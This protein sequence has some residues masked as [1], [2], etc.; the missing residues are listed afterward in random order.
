MAGTMKVAGINIPISAETKEFKSE[1]KDV[2]ADLRHSA[3]LGK[4]LNTALKLD[5]TS[6]E[7]AEKAMN[8][9]E[10]QIKQSEQKTELLNKEFERL[11]KLDVPEEEMQKLELQI[12]KSKNQTQRLNNEFDKLDN[13][14][15]TMQM[16]D[17]GEEL[18]DSLQET[19]DNIEDINR[20]LSRMEKL[21][22]TAFQKITGEAY[23]TEQGIRDID[24]SMRGLKGAAATGAKAM[25]AG[26]VAMTVGA[27]AVTNAIGDLQDGL[28]SLGVPP[29]IVDENMD[30]F[31][32]WG[33]ALGI[34]GVNANTLFKGLIKVSGAAV[35][36][37]KNF[38]KLGI[39][40]E[41]PNGEMKSMNELIPELVA[42]IKTIED[43][44]KQ[45]AVG[46]IFFGAGWKEVNKILAFGGI[47]ALQDLKTAI[48]ESITDEDIQ[49][50]I[51]F[52]TSVDK[53]S[54][55][56]KSM[57]LDVLP[58]FIDHLERIWEVVGPIITSLG[59]LFDSIEELR[60]ELNRLF[61]NLER[62]HE[63]FAPLELMASGI[64]GA[65]D[66]ITGAIEALTGALEELTNR[67]W[68]I[69]GEGLTNIV[70]NAVIPSSTIPTTSLNALSPSTQATSTSRGASPQQRTKVFNINNLT[71]K[72]DVKDLDKFVPDLFNKLDAYAERIS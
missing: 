49:T 58:E 1:M 25:L 40:L 10:K 64:A 47:P 46:T 50:F 57:V 59:D 72:S 34:A 24:S 66:L 19:E 12:L 67:D 52:T 41:H 9:L 23:H 68:F 31:I 53:V 2:N 26:F 29:E 63:L 51:D 54:L 8:N 30:S 20:E 21:G 39:S 11:S 65:I 38:E 32:S 7:I 61:P 3:Q 16:G 36:G 44:L 70:G 14:I 27:V 4:E 6:I 37:S 33:F 15:K 56:I 13:T 60:N 22:G 43:P 69:E 5:P 35:K 45:M 48:D 18:N 55:A 42:T 17:V 71:I 28:Y 62:L